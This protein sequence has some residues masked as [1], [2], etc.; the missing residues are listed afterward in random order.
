MKRYEF[1]EHTADI[2]VRLYGG[3]LKE[4]LISAALALSAAMVSKRKNRQGAVLIEK[5][6]AVKAECME[7]LLKFWLDELFY[8]FSTKGFVLDRIKSLECSQ[9]ALRAAV[10]LDEFD[11]EH[12]EFINEVKAVT[13]GD[14]KVEKVGKRWRAKVIF[15]V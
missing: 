4:L 3:S 12:Y 6:I 15:D 5:T 7:E 2:A 1:V 14:L 13:F 8:Y 9:H 11:L 10:L